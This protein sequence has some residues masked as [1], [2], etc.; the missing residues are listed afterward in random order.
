MPNPRKAGF[1][2]FPLCGDLRKYLPVVNANNKKYVFL[3]K[4]MYFCVMYFPG[5]FCL[6]INSFN[7]SDIKILYYHVYHYYY[8]YFYILLQSGYEG[9]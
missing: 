3:G 2:Q 1:V 8:Y 4:V 7:T 6:Q 5:V 9:L